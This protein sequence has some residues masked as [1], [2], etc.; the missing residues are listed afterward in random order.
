MKV[1]DYQ[2][3]V[4]AH[5]RDTSLSRVTGIQA[6]LLVENDDGDKASKYLN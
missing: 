2:I 6:L 5:E 4:T 3:L 1:A